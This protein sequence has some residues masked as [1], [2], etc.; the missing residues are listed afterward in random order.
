MSE[1]GSNSV[2]KLKKIFNTVN[3]D[4]LEK[5][6]DSYVPFNDVEF[7]AQQVYNLL[8]DDL[9]MEDAFIFGTAEEIAVR[10]YHIDL[11]ENFAVC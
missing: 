10:M 2:F 5:D 7:Y 3:R 9:N 11:V 8:F 4:C 6:P 1:R